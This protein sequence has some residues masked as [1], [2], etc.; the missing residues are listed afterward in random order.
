MKTKT[1]LMVAGAGA[2]GYLLWKNNKAKPEFTYDSRDD[3]G[4]PLV[5]DVAFS[6]DNFQLKIECERSGGDWVQPQ[7]IQAPCRG[8]CVK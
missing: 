2:L 4:M 8:I 6:K 5:Q 1:L 3:L 7:C